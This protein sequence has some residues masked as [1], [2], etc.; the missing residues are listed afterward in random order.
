MN[1]EI[2]E[3]IDD[4]RKSAHLDYIY[5]KSKAGPMYQRSGE[6]E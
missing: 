4:P 1:E 2:K 3:D 6:P 5:L